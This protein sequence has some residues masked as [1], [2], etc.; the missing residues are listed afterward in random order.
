MKHKFSF[1]LTYGMA[2]LLGG[3]GALLLLVGEK[4]PHPSQMENRMLAGF[5][6]L[7]AKAVQDGSFMEGLE[8]YLS[9]NMLERDQLVAAADRL[10]GCFSLATQ[11]DDEMAQEALFAQVA[12]FA[13]EGEAQP[14]G[15][16]ETPEPAPAPTPEPTPTAEP[17]T[18][19]PTRDVSD[20]SDETPSSSDGTPEL[21]DTPEPERSAVPE[22]TEPTAAPTDTPQPEASPTPAPAKK[23]LS[24]IQPCYFTCTR[25]DGSVHTVYTFPVNNILRMIKTLNAYRAALP[26]EGHVFFAQPPFPGVAAN[27]QSGEFVSWGGELENTINEYSDE[28]VYMVSVQQVLQQPLLDGEYLFFTTDH[29]WTPRAACYT[30]N[31]LLATL[32]I[33]PKP[34]DSYAFHTYRDFYG[35]MLNSNPNLRST[36]RPDVLDVMIPETPVKGYCIAWD[37]SEREAP[38]IYEN[39]HTYMAFLGGTQGPWR[40]FETGVD[41]GR[42]CLVIGDSF[43]NCFVPFLT[44]YYE[45]VHATD[46]RDAYYDG[47]HASWTISEYI[48]KYGID[49]VY[50]IL[51]TASGV[52]TDYL[53]ESL[54]KYL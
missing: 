8:S 12:A 39:S 21:R 19:A 23:D 44:P 28:G 1:L 52:N 43:S 37:G 50:L 11:S 24:A 4:T 46:V 9:D 48:A 51:S 36:H 20:R 38:L 22:T 14:A 29:H 33:D 35:S 27:L 54:L 7:S 34:Y 13:Q 41:C 17:A 16:E 45:T 2:V 26:A 6:P 47:A 3:L 40:R 10:M 49:D 30:A 15:P 5:P 31:A 18:P 25:A 53:I 32:G 42:S